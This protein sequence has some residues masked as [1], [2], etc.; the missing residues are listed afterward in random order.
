[1]SDAVTKFEDALKEYLVEL[2]MLDDG[3]L[4]TAWCF[5]AE[6]ADF[7]DDG[8]SVMCCF[9]PGATVP[10]RIGMHQYALN[11]INGKIQLHVYEDAEDGDEE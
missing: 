11:V 7:R 8:E 5:V 4:L 3:E 1:M 10:R 9:S 2:D 6:S